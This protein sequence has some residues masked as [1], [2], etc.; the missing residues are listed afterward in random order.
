MRRGAPESPPLG[1]DEYRLIRNTLYAQTGL[2]FRDDQ[3]A[4]VERRLLTRVRALGLTGFRAYH[5]R[6]LTDTARENE[7]QEAV[8]ALTNHETYFFREITQ[9]RALIDDVLPRLPKAGMRQ[10]PVRILSAGCSTGE[11]P[12]SLAI[13]FLEARRSAG[14]TLVPLCEIV[15]TDLSRRVIER[16]RRGVYGDS[17]FRSLPIALKDRYFRPVEGGTTVTA[18]LRAQVR[19]AHANI[20][21]RARMEAL[22]SFDVVLCRNVLI[23]F[24]RDA[25]I[26]AVSDFFDILRPG[27]FLMLGHAESLLSVSTEFRVAQLASGLAY[28]KPLPTGEAGGG[29]RL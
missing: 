25:K 3:R 5:L 13:L 23:Y 1:D 14:R 24:D 26:R 27:G 6:L 7:F 17:A 10:G 18:E 22:G 20:L 4:Y 12:F 29:S 8:E 9:L 16:A 21:D 11:E 19:F 15:A 2:T 28:Q